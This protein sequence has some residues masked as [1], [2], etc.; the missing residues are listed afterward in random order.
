V[1]PT[2]AWVVSQISGWLESLPSYRRALESWRLW[3]NPYSGAWDPVPSAVVH[4]ADLRDEIQAAPM[5]FHFALSV[6][7]LREILCGGQVWPLQLRLGALDRSRVIEDP[8]NAFDV[9]KELRHLVSLQFTLERAGERLARKEDPRDLRFSILIQPVLHASAE[10]LPDAW[11]K[12]LAQVPRDIEAESLWDGEQLWIRHAT[13][14]R[15]PPG[16]LP[17]R[18]EARGILPEEAES[19]PLSPMTFSI[20]KG[21][22][23]EARSEIASRFRLEVPRLEQ[24]LS[25]SQGRLKVHPEALKIRNPR[26]L[27]S[28]VR[29]TIAVLRLTI[30]LVGGQKRAVAWSEFR[31]ARR[32]GRLEGAIAGVRREFERFHEREEQD[33]RDW[34]LRIRDTRE[35]AE[36]A[37][38]MSELGARARRGLA[39]GLAAWL[40][41]ESLMETMAPLMDL[42]IFADLDQSRLNADWSELRLAIEG[43]PEGEAWLR[44][45]GREGALGSSAAEKWNR[46]LEK[47]GMLHSS[48]ELGAPSWSEN[49]VLLL[50]LGA[51][52]RVRV[53]RPH[54]RAS[55]KSASARPIIA[56]ERQ[57]KRAI[58]LVTELERMIERHRRM[59]GVLRIAVRK[60][61]LGGGEAL[62]RKQF[63]RSREDVFLLGLHEM[64]DAFSPDAMTVR[65]LVDRRR[66][67]VKADLTPVADTDSRIIPV[68]LTRESARIRAQVN[69][70]TS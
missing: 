66:D 16:V 43:D 65:F 40:L 51:S 3:G 49:P 22:L 12:E 9:W 29:S 68:G 50:A 36:I 6:K 10:P 69:E 70:E 32:I 24:I 48:W 59:T 27:R 1:P 53:T 64:M 55:Q 21:F 39:R 52:P 20:L 35:P 57:L 11:K 8:R 41:H 17:L 2:A 37:V 42:S 4:L 45:A 46:F 62:V 25:L 58:A 30:E 56:S 34:M 61:L 38:R 28:A 33:L 44:S 13:Q 60:T 26:S 15:C 7:T 18:Q 5:P 14:R 19:A 63:I 67:Q 54:W 23:K 47:H 31:L